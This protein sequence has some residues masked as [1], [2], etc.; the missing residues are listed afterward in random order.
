MSAQDTSKIQRL[1]LG[2]LVLYLTVWLLGIYI[3]GFEPSLIE[4]EGS[5]IPLF[6]NPL[7]ITHFVFAAATTTVGIILLSLGWIYTLKKFVLLTGLSLASIAIAATGG[8]SF[9]FAIGNQKYDSMLMAASFITAV[10]LSFLSTLYSGLRKTPFKSG[11]RV[12]RSLAFAVLAMFYLVFLSGMYVNLFI[13]SS[14]FSEPPAVARQMLAGMVASFPA[15]FHETSGIL[16]L[17]L[18]ITLAVS[19]YRA[20]FTKLA[21]RGLICSLLVTYSLL[22]GVL[23]NILPIFEPLTTPETTSFYF[24]TSV[25]SPMLSAAGFLVAILIAM[26]VAQWLWKISPPAQRI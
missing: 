13:A 8:L 23:V 4:I 18:A 17:A 7:V 11:T 20:H 10:Y 22:E 12:L 21:I 3:N 25:I 26:N 15:L 19:L 2:Q 6:L 5:S 9:V 14:V 1:V 24:I 16:L